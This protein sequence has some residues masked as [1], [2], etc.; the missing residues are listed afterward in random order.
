M[1]MTRSLHRSLLTA[2]LLL[3][4][5]A[6][7]VPA[8]G[9]MGSTAAGELW[10]GRY[11][12]TG[13]TTDD[14]NAVAVSPDGS[15]VF[16]VGRSSGVGTGYDYATVAHNGL[17]G[18]PLWTQRYNGTGNGTDEATAVAVSPDGS[19]VFVTGNSLGSI[20]N[21]D[22]ATLAFNAATGAPLWTRRYNGLGN[23]DDYAKAIGVSPDGTKVYVTGF[24]SGGAIGY[25]Y[26]TVAI[27]A[28][29][30]VQLWERRYDGLNHKADEAFALAV[31]PDGSKVFV[32]GYADMGGTGIDYVTQA[33]N[34]TTGVGI[35]GKSYNGPGN[36][37]D[38]GY[39]IDVSP[40]GSKV[41]VTGYSWG[42]SSHN[43]YAT[44]A[45]NANTGASLWLRRYNGPDND[46][47]YAQG[48]AA[49]PDGSKVFVTGYSDGGS[50][51][52]DYATIAYSAATGAPI[53][54]QRYNGPGNGSD[55]AQAVTVTLDGVYVYATG[56]AAS[57]ASGND[58][59]T[60]AYFT[61]NGGSVGVRRYNGPGNGSDYGNAIAVSSSIAYVTGQ[62]Y[63]GATGDDYATAA[64]NI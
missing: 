28:S 7:I 22:Y 35:W 49:S 19:K 23:Q 38:Y 16:S 1:T 59:A 57:G 64:Y 36:S 56:Y 58:Y 63:G 33:I 4:L 27:D 6:A 44:I 11:N 20:S 50:S 37:S 41:F 14:A 39:A 5:T 21:Y 61:S 43:D 34:A 48:I 62:S 53:W 51:G 42:V 32:T 30:G 45:I 12:G 40:D 15:R 9:A 25:D 60:A 54:G 52:Y 17:T 24:S 29:T 3:A 8:G 26:A 31:S 10:V 46:Y 55:Y 18:A 47:D 2:S 13:N